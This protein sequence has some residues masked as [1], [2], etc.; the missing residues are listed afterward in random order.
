MSCPNPPHPERDDGERRRAPAQATTSRLIV[1]HI[2]PQSTTDDLSKAFAAFGEVVGARVTTR[3]GGAPGFGFVDFEATESVVAAAS[4][5]VPIVLDGWELHVRPQRNRN[6][7][8]IGGIPEDA[9]DADLEAAFA[10]YNPSEVRIIN[11][12]SQPGRRSAVIRFQTDEQRIAAC[13]ENQKVKLTGHDCRILLTSHRP[14]RLSGR[15]LY[16]SDV[17]GKQK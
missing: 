17:P 16:G 8:F 11:H 6:A 5:D 10:K 15:R 4:A 14:S 2:N 7:I 9:T 3:R 13:D 12:A 1:Q